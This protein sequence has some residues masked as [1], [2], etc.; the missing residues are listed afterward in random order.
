VGAVQGIVRGFQ[1]GPSAQAPVVR[2]NGGPIADTMREIAPPW[3]RGPADAFE[4]MQKRRQ[5]AGGAERAGGPLGPI[6]PAFE[7]YQRPRTPGPLWQGPPAPPARRETR[8]VSATWTVDAYGQVR[9]R[10]RR[11]NPLNL[12]ALRRSVAR[13]RSFRKIANRVEMSF[14]MRKARG[15][16]RPRPFCKKRR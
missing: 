4:A 13:L 15:P 7:R 16:C 3:L 11:M 10:R 8:G 12:K 5:A 1:G 2:K 14:P 9:T 6:E